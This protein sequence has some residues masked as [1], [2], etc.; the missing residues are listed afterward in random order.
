MQNV[1][2]FMHAQK[3]F[4]Y[5]GPTVRAVR[6]FVYTRAG[7]AGLVDAAPR[8]FFAV[9]RPNLPNCGLALRLPRLDEK[10]RK[11]YKNG[12]VRYLSCENLIFSPATC[13]FASEKYAYG[14]FLQKVTVRAK[15][16]FAQLEG[17]AAF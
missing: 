13:S 7:A 11:L 10:W 15:N 1:S 8:D 14:R 4:L 17:G 6:D 2:Y 3:K 16:T 9:R 12:R 5:F